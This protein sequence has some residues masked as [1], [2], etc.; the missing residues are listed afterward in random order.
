M[1]KI[2]KQPK[3]K[4]KFKVKVSKDDIEKY[5]E[6][7]AKDYSTQNPIKGF[8]P[9]K[10]PVEK[11]KE[12]MGQQKF[13]E[14]VLDS[15]IQKEY[16]KTILNNEI[17]AIGTPKIDLGKNFSGIDNEFDFEVEVA[18]FPKLKMPDLKEI[19]FEK[20]S[21]NK[22]K[23]ESKE[24]DDV[25][26]RIRESR[27]KLVTVKR[28]A[29]KG[30][31][32]E[33]D[34]KIFLNKVPYENGSAKDF[35]VTIGKSKDQLVPG[36]EDKLIGMKEN[37]TK[38]F[39]LK[40]PPKY[41]D[42]NLAD[43]EVEFEVLMKLV[44]ERQLPKLE[45]NFAKEIGQYKSLQDLKD[46]IKENLKQEKERKTINQSLDKAL[47]QIIEKVKTE[48]PQAM[49]DEEKQKMYN[50]LTANVKQMGLDMP[51]Y[52]K[53]IKKTKEEIFKEWEQDAQKRIKGALILKEI[54]ALNKL[55]PKRMEIAQKMELIKTQN[56]DL[57]DERYLKDYAK[58][59]V[60]NQM[61]IDWIKKELLGLT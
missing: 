16:V 27:V 23:I 50:E 5:K 34:F 24:I 10:A 55:N 44:Q 49:I 60:K 7:T 59:L 47:N 26:E 25:L 53:H 36:F 14:K 22:I 32:V 8:R 31:R 45:D 9:G 28:P 51:D 21:L 41:H 48:I 61:A 43:K 12:E 46:H 11:V 57:K 52:F 4:V 33:I 17:K 38:K 56:P 3:S 15:A 19:K 35:P 39:K 18:V 2:E 58:M 40:F 6:M 42:K 30:D 20:P 54:A 1:I 37:E 13:M 29:K